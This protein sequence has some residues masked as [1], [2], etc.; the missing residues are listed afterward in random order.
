M[1]PPWNGIGAAPYRAHVPMP[2]APGHGLPFAQS[3]PAAPEVARPPGAVPPAYWRATL[4]GWAL[5]ALGVMPAVAPAQPMTLPDDPFARPTL[6]RVP[7][8]PFAKASTFR[9][10][11]V[12]P[13]ATT[14]PGA[15]AHRSGR[16]A[17]RR[18]TIQPKPEDRV[19]E[20]RGQSGPSSGMVLALEEG[21]NWNELDNEG[22]APDAIEGDVRAT[23]AHLY[24]ETYPAYWAARQKVLDALKADGAMARA[25][26]S[27]PVGNGLV[28][29]DQAEQAWARIGPHLEAITARALAPYVMDE[30]TGDVNVALERLRASRKDDLDGDGVPRDGLWGRAVKPPVATPELG[31]PGAVGPGSAGP[32]VYRTAPG[33]DVANQP[34]DAAAVRFRDTQQVDPRDPLV[35]KRP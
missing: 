14:R 15:A 8:D 34:L 28:T 5:P 6:P 17:R 18:Q 1:G 23:L 4:P 31:W 26:R 32:R 12:P 35:T 11:W 2:G 27:M 33:R 22:A 19:P 9:P 25:F 29:E 24:P 16:S 13:R 30:P 20:V 10:G 21:I 3:A 7:D